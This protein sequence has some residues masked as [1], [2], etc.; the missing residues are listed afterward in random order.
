MEHLRCAVVLVLDRHSKKTTIIH[1]AL[2]NIYLF[3]ATVTFGYVPGRRV[4]TG[5]E[6]AVTMFLWR[7][8]GYACISRS[9]VSSF[10]LWDIWNLV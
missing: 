1:F 4:L 2:E 8:A 7:L 10:V 3:L 6:V 5:M 9:S